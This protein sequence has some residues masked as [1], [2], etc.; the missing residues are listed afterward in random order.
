M[1]FSFSMFLLSGQVI[2][3]IQGLVL[4]DFFN[5]ISIQVMFIVLFVLICIFSIFNNENLL[6]NSYQ[7]CYRR[8]KYPL[9]MAQ[10]NF[11][12]L[13]EASSDP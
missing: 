5:S 12:I 6:Q 11:N 8:R 4:F 13:I 2:M 9:P 3:Y 10:Y 7:N 1:S